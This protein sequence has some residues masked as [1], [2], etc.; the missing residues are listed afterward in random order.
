MRK[1]LYGIVAAVVSGVAISVVLASPASAW[2]NAANLK[3]G[4]EVC[5]PQ[6]QATGARLYGSILN[7]SGTGSIRVAS[8]AGGA[9]TVLWSATGSN[10]NFDKSLVAPAPGTF[11]RGCVKIT[12]ATSNTWTKFGLLPS[13][14]IT[15]AG[16]HTALL[17][18]GARFCGG[19]GEGR[20]RLLGTANAAVTFSVNGFDQDYQSIGPVFSVTGTS[21]D[22]VF[23][24]S[25]DLTGLEMCVNNTSQQTVAASFKLVQA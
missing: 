12:A 4:N 21:V 14:T 6:V 22:Q 9:E 18:P 23:T 13:G 25:P 3:V 19:S 20:V 5:S 1:R 10:L 16:S 2:D 7:G 17:S 24:S 11:F 8:S 15:G